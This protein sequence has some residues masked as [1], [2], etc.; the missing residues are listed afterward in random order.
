MLDHLRHQAVLEAEHALG[1][2]FSQSWRA[3][4]GAAPRRRGPLRGRHP[5]PPAVRA[6]RGLPRGDEPVQCRYTEIGGI[7][8]AGPLGDGRVEDRLRPLVRTLTAGGV[9]QRGGPRARTTGSTRRPAATGPRSPRDNAGCGLPNPAL[10]Y[11]NRAY[12][13]AAHLQHPDRPQGGLRP[14]RAPARRHVRLRRDG[15]RPEPPRARPRRARLRR[16]APLPGLRRL[17]GDLRAQLHRHRRQDH[18]ARRRARRALAGA[19]RDAT[20]ASTSST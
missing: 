17:P 8:A 14:D 10:G 12:H 7:P 15:L 18:Q 9:A 20:S 2:G 11:D 4:L 3:G 1:F 16:R 13:D 6:R 19:R 5:D